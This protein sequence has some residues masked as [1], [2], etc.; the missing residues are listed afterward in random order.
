MRDKLD[1]LDV[2]IIE[3]LAKYGPR[4]VTEIARKLNVSRGTILSRIKRMS[5]L[6]YLRPLTNV[7]HTNIGLKKAVVFAK[8]TPGYEELLFDCL[9]VNKF[10]IYLTRCY[11]AFEGYIGIYVIP[12]NSTTKFVQ[13]IEEIKKL[14][15][16]DHIRVFWSTCFHTVNR[17]SNWFD[18]PSETWI[19][20][21]DKWIK[22][23]PAEETKLPYTLVDPKDFPLRADQIDLFIVK[24][25]EKD[26]TINLT[27]IAKKLGTTLQNVHYHYKRHVIKH[28]LIEDFQ[29]GILPFDRTI[30]DMFS[31]AFKFDSWEKMAKFAR[32]LLDKP[33]A[34]SVGKVLGENAIVVQLYLP[35]Q[36]FRNFIEHLSKL[37]RAGF[38]QTYEYV[39]QDLSPGKWSRE[40]IPYEFFK[41][42][43]WEYNHD[44][45]M[46]ELQNL[47]T[48]AKSTSS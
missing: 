25:L 11:G 22:E 38:L 40:T 5:S 17:T 24:E 26:A 29:I 41:H 30:S 33:F 2:K 36:E 1:L 16:A 20:P 47:V 27:V 7:Y 46:Q 8:A 15:V 21:W 14:G 23:I 39:I 32:S 4:N 45:Y 19:F 3:G 13:F 35:R 6:F 34:F 28:G 44:R 31:F 37:I 9:K 10:H 12:K 43:S 18:C 48:Q 42:G